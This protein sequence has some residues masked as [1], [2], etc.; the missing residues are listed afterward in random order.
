VRADFCV[1]ACTREHLAV[2]KARFILVSLH[3][4]E[5]ARHTALQVRDACVSVS[6]RVLRVVPADA[7]GERESCVCARV[8]AGTLVDWCMKV[9][10][11]MCV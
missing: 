2:K 1:R 4:P 11:Y 9:C 10:E 8:R 3:L 6:I 7:A 5:A